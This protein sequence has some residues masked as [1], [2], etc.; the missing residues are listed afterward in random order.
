MVG[1]IVEVQPACCDGLAKVICGKPH[2]RLHGVKD[3]QIVL[4]LDTEDIHVIAH[5]TKE[6]NEIEGVV[7]VYPVFSYGSLP[8]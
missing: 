4:I 6:I 8:F 3:N 5:S 7:G 1:L 2:I